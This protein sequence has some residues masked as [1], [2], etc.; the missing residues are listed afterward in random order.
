[1]RSWTPGTPATGVSSSDIPW[2][3]SQW[4]GDES[5]ASADESATDPLKVYNDAVSQIASLTDMKTVEQLTFR[6]A[7]DWESATASEKALCEERVDEACQAVCKVIAP[8]ASG[9]LLEAYKNSPTLDKGESA[10]TAAYIQAPTKNLKTENLII[11]ALQCSCSE[12]QN[13]HAH[14][15]KLSDR[16]IKKARA[17][18]K[19]VGAGLVLEKAPF[20]RT[21][22]DLMRLNHFL[23]FADQ[24]YFCQD[25]SHGTRT[26]SLD[27][28]EHLIMPNVVR[29]VARS[30]VIAQYFRHCHGEGF[31]PLGR[32][33]L[34]QILKVRE[35]SQR[36]SLQGLDNIAARRPDGFDALTKIFDDL[37]QSGSRP[38]W[39]EP[40]RKE[41]KE[42]NR[43]LKKE[44]RAHC[45]ED[46]S[47]CPDHCT[48][49]ALS[50]PQSTHF[51][52]SCDHEH[53]AK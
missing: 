11:Y 44:Y 7:T 5:D 21:R 34:F 1:M 23:S 29:T 17:H 12:L 2:T 20:H 40:T 50:D 3:P 31:E 22:I 6:L 43:Y 30:T 51:Q 36:K 35:A 32:S 37:E 27:S 8:N 18:A 52:A 4:R 28:G 53:C 19:T 48:R 47:P 13:M 24:P 9:G 25:V 38:E 15:E 14:F 42:G 33:T 41:L 45:R 39:C 26:L 49:Y 16:Q 10:L 46:E